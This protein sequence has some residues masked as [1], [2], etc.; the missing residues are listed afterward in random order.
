MNN[1]YGTGFIEKQRKQG[2]KST[3]YAMAEIVDNSIDADAKNIDIVLIEENQTR[4]KS[5]RSVLSQIFF[6]DDGKGMDEDRLNGCLTF[7]Q[8]E[9]VDNKRIGAFGVGLPNSS[10]SVGRKVEVYSRVDGQKW[11]Y[12]E[13]DLDDQKSRTEPGFDQAI[14]KDPKFDIPYTISNEI[15]T[16]IKWSKLDLIDV[17]RA[18]T[19]IERSQ[20]L[21]GRIYRYV[22]GN[23]LKIKI[24]SA[25]LGNS[26]L[27]TNLEDIVLYDPLFLTEELNFMTEHIWYWSKNESKTGRHQILGDDE[28][29]NSMYHYR[30]FTDGYEE[31]VNSRAIFQKHDDFHDVLYEISI[32]GKKY[33]FTIKASLAGKHITNPGVRSGGSTEIGKLLGKKMSG[34]K[35]FKSGNIFFVRANREIDFGHFGLYTVTDEKNRF[36]TIE[37]HFDSDLDELMGVSNTKQSVG[38]FATSA[39]DSEYTERDE[40]IAEGIKREILYSF[41]TEKIATC[42][43]QMRKIHKGYAKQFKIEEEAELA[44]VG[45]DP[46]K[47]PMPQVE[48][49]VWEVMPKGDSEWSQEKKEDVAKFLKGKYMHLPIETIRSQVE[50]FSKG[51]T[52]T[53]V[54]YA[55]NE[56]NLLFELKEKRGV[57]ITIIN[58]NHIYYTNILEPL[59]SS[60][61]LTV[62]AISIEMLIS[63]FALE[64]HKL[65]LDNSEKY[66]KP[67]E[68]YLIQLSSRLN[69]F[70]DDSEILIKPE[71]LKSDD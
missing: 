28:R 71:E 26:R 59:K 30:K 58:T 70:I 10:I 50:I 55:S 1:L 38:F 23:G 19:L 7:S 42:I 62:F 49:L 6:F 5:N 64:I 24:G 48:S 45:D 65:S 57:L 14:T 25:N 68:T 34:I 40:N 43:K 9:G 31:G 46:I 54:I 52:R 56:S 47:K 21:L 20:N 29:F 12:V 39:G 22:L 32:G 4:G 51:L 3:V 67:L 41:M 61:K 36:W 35:H 33:A 16:I 15:R 66:S 37:V 27:T 11:K 60:R 17:A 53:M 69:E 63:S 2:Y 18:T 44:S 13:L 8:G